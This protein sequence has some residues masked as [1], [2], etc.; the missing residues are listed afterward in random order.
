MCRRCSEKN[1]FGVDISKAKV[2]NLGQENKLKLSDE[3]VAVMRYPTVDQL[4]EI[5][6]IRDETEQKFRTLAAA[7]KTIYYKDEV[8][9]M[10]DVEPMEVIAFLDNRS[11]AEISVI[12]TFIKN[13]PTVVLESSYKCMKCG[14]V[15]E[16]KI[17]TLSDFF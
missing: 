17:T 1:E 13:V 16:F 14:N 8:F 11:D 12:D 2:E 6:M 4:A 10:D 9:H 5:S 15:N 7:I 3:L